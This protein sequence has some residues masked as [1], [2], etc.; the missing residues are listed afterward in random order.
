MDW[1]LIGIGVEHQKRFNKQR[2][3]LGRLSLKLERRKRPE[4][5]RSL[6]QREPT[7]HMLEKRMKQEQEMP[8]RD[9]PLSKLDIT[10]SRSSCVLLRL[11]QEMPRRD[12]PLS[13]LDIM[14]SRSSCVLLRLEQE[15]LSP[16][17]EM[18]AHNWTSKL[19]VPC[20]SIHPFIHWLTKQLTNSRLIFVM[21][22]RSISVVNIV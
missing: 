1:R 7:R 13:K 21:T 12:L 20:S 11:E 19:K 6:L 5:K 22:V 8:R 10:L 16:T 17:L 14:L 9:L 15:M 3:E 2:N 4:L 18:L